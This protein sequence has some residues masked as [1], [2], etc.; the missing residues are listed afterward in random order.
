MTLHVA[1]VYA[2]DGI[3]FLTAARSAE[4]LMGKVAA[5]IEENVEYLLR[6]EDSVRVRALLAEARVPDAVTVYFERV[7]ERWEREY[8]RTEI[9]ESRSP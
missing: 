5:Y 8:L 6:P 4:E 7:G 1:V 3:R 2:V 9:V